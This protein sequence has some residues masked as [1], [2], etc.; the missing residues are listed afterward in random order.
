M[1]KDYQGEI[2]ISDYHVGPESKALISYL[3][4]VNYID[5]K[6]NGKFMGNYFKDMYQD[7]DIEKY[8]KL[9]KILKLD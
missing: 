9:L 7:F 6:V 2:K 1:L 8:Y 5:G 4:D 3:P